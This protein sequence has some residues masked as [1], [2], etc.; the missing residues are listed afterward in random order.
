M[1]VPMAML[2]DRVDLVAAVELHRL[3]CWQVDL[4]TYPACR[5]LKATTAETVA[6]ELISLVGVGEQVQLAA[7]N[8]LQVVVMAE[9]ARLSTPLEFLLHTQA[10]VAAVDICQVTT[11]LVVQEGEETVEHQILGMPIP[12]VAVVAHRAT[13]VTA[14]TEDR[15]S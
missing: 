1:V 14:E 8:H 2:A 11:V 3:A 6:L 15:V 12:V 4:V 9:M 10:V 13:A 5:H 7:L